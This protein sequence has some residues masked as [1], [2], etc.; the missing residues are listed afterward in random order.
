MTQF[1]KYWGAGDKQRFFKLIFNSTQYTLFLLALIGVPV[2]LEIDYV[3]KLWLNEVPPYTASFVKITVIC[4]LIYRSNTMVDNGINAAGYVKQLNTMSIPIYLLTIPLVYMALKLGWG[5]IVAYWFASIPALLSFVANLWILSKYTGFPGMRFL[6]YI[7]IK[8]FLLIMLA[9][10]IPYIVQSQMQESV[11][12]F[13]VV[14]SLSI[15]CTIFVLYNWGINKDVRIK[16][17]EKLHT[18]LKFSNR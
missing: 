7:V 16:L 18:F 2:I 11:L 13:F 17:N 10:A 1:V 14:C 3:L 4:S 9:M 8:I 5:P 12:R 15:L 6:V